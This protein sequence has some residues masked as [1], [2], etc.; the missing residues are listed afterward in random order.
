MGIK[1]RQ[2]CVNNP[3]TESPQSPNS[4]RIKAESGM[5]GDSPQYVIRPNTVETA[6]WQWKEANAS[7]T[8]KESNLVVSWQD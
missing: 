8:V 7:P 4:E 6:Y 3:T 5:S 2:G 1:N